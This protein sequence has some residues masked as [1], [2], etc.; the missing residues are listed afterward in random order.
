MKPFSYFTSTLLPHIKSD[1]IQIFS[2]DHVINPSNVTCYIVTSNNSNKIIEF[3]HE[4]RQLDESLRNL[5]DII[6]NS[7]TKVVKYGIVVFFSSYS[8]MDFVIN[9]WK[10]L[11]YYNQLQSLK[12]IFIEPKSTTEGDKLLLRYS[13]EATS[14]TEE[15]KGAILFCVMGG[16]LSEG[17]NFSDK[18][19]RVVIVVG[20]PYPDRRDTVLQEKLNYANSKI[21]NGGKL[22]Y[23]SMCMK[24]VNQSIGRSI[25]HIN[26]YAAIILLDQRYQQQTVINLLPNWISRSIEIIQSPNE[27]KYKLQQFLTEKELQYNN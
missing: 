22:L 24:Q 26:D 20:M 6:Y 19:A 9:R 13:H 1:K 21:E 5:F 14:M 18:L 4:T 3:T 27:M 8:Y 15:S 12:P 25:R 23:E 10:L 17:I 11:G 2:C 16:K 7:V